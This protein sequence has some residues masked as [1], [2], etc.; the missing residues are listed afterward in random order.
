MSQ[1]SNILLSS[2]FSNCNSYLIVTLYKC[3][4]KAAIEFTKKVLFNK[5]NDGVLD[6]KT[7]LLSQLRQKIPQ[8]HILPRYPSQH[9]KQTFQTRLKHLLN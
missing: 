3:L 1:E 6:Q 9:L 8:L 2:L 5:Q 7:K 4:K